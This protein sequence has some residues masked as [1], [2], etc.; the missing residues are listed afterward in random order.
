[1]QQTCD[2]DA[3]KTNAASDRKSR[4]HVIGPNIES[5]SL[6]NSATRKIVQ[7]FYQTGERSRIHIRMLIHFI[8]RT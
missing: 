1:M 6:T 7:H 3:G 2:R 8:T 5:L 4:R